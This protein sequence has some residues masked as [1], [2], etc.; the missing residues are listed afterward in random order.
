[1]PCLTPRAARLL[2]P[3][4][5]AALLGLSACKDARL[6]PTRTTA[7]QSISVGGISSAPLAV[8]TRGGVKVAV[9]SRKL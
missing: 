5:S 7:V 6:S 9:T 4:V 3:L 2:V 8:S 1:M